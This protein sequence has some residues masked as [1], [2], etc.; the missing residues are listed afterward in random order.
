[1]MARFIPWIGALVL[2]VSA[3]AMAGPPV[4]EQVIRRGIDDVLDV[5]RDPTTRPAAARAQR[6]ARLRQVAD[7][8]FDW[9]EMSQRSLGPTWRTLDAAQRKR[10]A[11]VFPDILASAYLDDLDK[12]RGDERVTI[13]RSTESGDHAE[14]YTSVVTHGG[15]R[16]PM[17]YWLHNVEAAWRVYDFS[18]EGVSLVNH[19]RESFGRFLVNHPFEDLMERLERKRPKPAAR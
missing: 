4:A 17:V 1:M 8:L 7:R 18:V 19:Y 12:F 9:P 14:V 15:E 5:L 3:V 13:E 16:V 6:I 11:E 10:F 2:A